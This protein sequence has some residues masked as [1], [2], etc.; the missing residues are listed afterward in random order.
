M[1]ELMAQL[2]SELI[3]PQVALLLNYHDIWAIQLQPHRKGFDYLRH[4][5]VF[6]V[7]P[8]PGDH[9]GYRLLWADLGA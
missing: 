8:A 6:T 7:P 3:Q 4:L 2:A 1:S 5:F 9:Y